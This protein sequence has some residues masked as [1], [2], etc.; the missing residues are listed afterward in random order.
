MESD[1]AGIIA[2]EWRCFIYI[3]IFLRFYK[4]EIG[5]YNHFVRIQRCFN[6]Q[7]DRQ[8]PLERRHRKMPVKIKRHIVGW[9]R[10]IK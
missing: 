5:K 6:G 8:R 9:K 1:V 10:P 3:Y 4:I 7:T 2:I